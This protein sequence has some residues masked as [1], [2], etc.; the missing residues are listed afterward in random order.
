MEGFTRR[1]GVGRLVLFEL[2][3]TMESAMTR[4]KRIKKWNRS[5]RIE[6]IE[7]GNPEWRH[8]WPDIID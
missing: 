7:A 1:Y 4:E 3:G 8:L 6:L 2:H 5:W